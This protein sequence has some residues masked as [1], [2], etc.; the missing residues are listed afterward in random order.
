M[1]RMRALA[2]MALWTAA[3]A[4]QAVPVR[5]EPRQFCR[6]VVTGHGGRL[7]VLVATYAR[8]DAT[9]TLYA[10]L[11][12]AEPEHY[13]LLQ[14]RFAAH[15]GLLY[16]WIGDADMRPVPGTPRSNPIARTLCL[17][18]QVGHIDY[19]CANFVHA[20]MTARQ[21]RAAQGEAGRGVFGELAPWDPDP[22]RDAEAAAPRLDLV[23]AFRAGRGTHAMRLATARW[24]SSLM[25]VSRQ[26]TV[27][28]EGRNERC[29]AVLQRELAAGRRRL[30]IYYGAL[31]MPHLEQRLV[32]DLGWTLTS[33]QWLTAWDNRRDV[34][35]VAEK[36]L[37]RKRYRARR[38]LIGLREVVR[39][40]CERNPV[41]T[42]DWPQVRAAQ[43]HGHLPGYADGLDPWGRAYVLFRDA[44]RWQVRCVG[45]DGREGSEDDLTSSDTG[46][47]GGLLASLWDYVVAR[48]GFE[49]ALADERRHRRGLLR[50]LAPRSAARGV[51]PGKDER[52]P[53]EGFEADVAKLRRLADRN[54]ERARTLQRLEAV[55]RLV[56][57]HEGRGPMP[58][59]PQMLASAPAVELAACGEGLDGWGRPMRLEQDGKGGLQVRSDGPD[60]LHGTE[61]DLVR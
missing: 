9:L 24:L 20:D 8:G 25:Q 44:G 3:L 21:F 33:E 27:L 54:G 50:I 40:W 39:A 5:D 13:D 59:L 42:P 4:A 28:I 47:R 51:Q 18:E 12:V 43:L 16:E 11:H 56:A 55:R 52:A 60:G 23:G 49:R 58:D 36:G 1:A 46:D 15:D 38:D 2:A 61:D 17:A 34:F 14:Q 29:L 26:P 31:H 35:P 45:S 7:E 53:R 37:H 22:D 6:N 10:A 57:R 48:A 19:R 30:G 32:H 41:A